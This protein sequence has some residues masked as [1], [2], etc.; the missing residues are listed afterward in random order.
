MVALFV[1][2]VIVALCEPDR[3]FLRLLKLLE[4]FVKYSGYK[5]NVNKT[6][7]LAIIY[8]PSSLIS[9]QHRLKW[10]TKSTTYLGMIIT[11]S[12]KEFNYYK[13]NDH[14]KLGIRQQSAF[15]LHSNLI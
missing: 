3:N 8:S 5:L 9:K 2:D 12:F 11:K 13:I 6:Q 7:T 1:D 10:K 14:I 15:N 4:E